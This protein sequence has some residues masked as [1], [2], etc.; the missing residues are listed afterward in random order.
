[1]EVRGRDRQGL[2]TE[3]RGRVL[4]YCIQEAPSCIPSTAKQEQ[5][6]SQMLPS[7]EVE[8]QH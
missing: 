3:V 5:Q 8:L 6:K 1:M 7:W 4:D 2:D